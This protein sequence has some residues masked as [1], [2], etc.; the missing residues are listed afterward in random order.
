[1][2]LM[3]AQD[4]RVP[5]FGLNWKDEEQPAKK[6]LQQRG[7]PYVEIAVDRDNKTGID[8]GVYGAPETFIVDADGIIRYKHVGPITPDIWT[9]EFMPRIAQAKEP[10]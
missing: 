7:N 8:W 2:L 3:I 9:R 6:W 4:G 5:I 1:M 10:M